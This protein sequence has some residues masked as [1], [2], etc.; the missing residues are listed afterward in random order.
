MHRTERRARLKGCSRPWQCENAVRELDAALLVDPNDVDGMARA[1][2]SA[3][4]MPLAERRLRFQAMMQRL[5]SQSIQRWFADFVRALRR[6]TQRSRQSRSCRTRRCR[7]G[8]ARSA[9]SSEHDG[10]GLKWGMVVAPQGS[11]GCFDPI[12]HVPPK[13]SRCIEPIKARMPSSEQRPPGR[14]HDQPSANARR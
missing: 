2:A 10:R 7:H 5:R 9:P 3:M 11:S 1:I 13:H 6:G 8:S 4:S 14:A 12:G